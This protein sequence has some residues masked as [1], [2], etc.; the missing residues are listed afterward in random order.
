MHSIRRLIVILSLYLLV[1][2]QAKSSLNIPVIYQI[3]QHRLKPAHQ[4]IATPWP[5]LDKPECAYHAT[6]NSNLPMPVATKKKNYRVHQRVSASPA[7]AQIMHAKAAKKLALQELMLEDGIVT[8]S[9][10]YPLNITELDKALKNPNHK[11]VLNGIRLKLEDQL[12]E[13]LEGKVYKIKDPAAQYH[14]LKIY[15]TA[16]QAAQQGDILAALTIKKAQPLIN[17]PE[18][19]NVKHKY[20]VFQ[21]LNKTLAEYWEDTSSDD[22]SY[23]EKAEQLFGFLFTLEN[24]LAE[25]GFTLIDSHPGNI[26]VDDKGNFKRI[27]LA[28]LMPL[29]PA[30]LK[31]AYIQAAAAG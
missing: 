19:I 13:G 17:M 21:L 23:K 6:A 20:S 27:D 31:R 28:T 18:L 5:G 12:G 4:H 8:K 2:L 26:M 16:F 25:D 10:I 9:H 22:I 30:S 29:C 15:K 24:K 1:P 7:V 14:A 11:L 3:T